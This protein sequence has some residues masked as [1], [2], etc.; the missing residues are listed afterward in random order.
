MKIE[1]RKLEES[2]IIEFRKLGVKT[3]IIS[4]S[5]DGSNYMFEFEDEPSEQELKLI[6]RIL[7]SGIVQVKK[8]GKWISLGE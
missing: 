1:F 3:K 8:K 4:I 6:G 7:S 2:P 5:R